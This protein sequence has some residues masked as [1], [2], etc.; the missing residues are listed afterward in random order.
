MAV[1]AWT[2]VRAHVATFDVSGFSNEA[3]IDIAT[4]PLDFTTFG[5]G[6]WKVFKG[7][8]RSFTWGVA[9]FQDHAALSVDEKIGFS[10]SNF[11]LPSQSVFSLA[12]ASAVGSVAYFGLI[13]QG[14][15]LPVSAKF[16]EQARFQ[17]AGWGRGSLYR[18]T[19]GR[20]KATATGV[21]DGTEQ[22]LGSQNAK[23]LWAALHVFAFSGTTAT[24]RIGSSAT[25]GGALT[26]ELSFTAVTAATSE[27]A[28]VAIASTRAYW[29]VRV[30][31][32]TFTS[33]SFAV[34][35]GFV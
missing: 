16:G 11:A 13:D 34:V 2:D 35:F 33:M 21:E 23:T 12:S 22:N 7:G 24:V 25:S 15:Y 32:G 26:N 29:K 20:T 1:Q 3:A 4:E 14:S 8:V 6:S 9:G 27:L 17:A 5:D 30:T 19:V 10:E 28:S 18:G 31:G